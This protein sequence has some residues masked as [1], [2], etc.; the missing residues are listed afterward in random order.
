MVENQAYGNSTTAL[1]EGR[2]EGRRE[3]QP[4]G[5][6]PRQRTGQ[7]NKTPTAK[8]ITAQHTTASRTRPSRDLISADYNNN[9]AMVTGTHLFSASLERGRPGGEW[10]Y[11]GGTI[12]NPTITISGG[13]VYFIETDKPLGGNGRR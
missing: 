2:Q 10:V 9:Q 4:E 5:T 11:E 1:K 12:L 6:G 8:N 3:G 13:R 7:N